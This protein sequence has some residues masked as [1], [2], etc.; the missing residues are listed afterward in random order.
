M[1]QFQ[2]FPKIPRLNREVVVTEK[3][4]GTN[5]AVVI[6]K[7]AAHPSIMGIDYVGQMVSVEGEWYAVAAQSRNRLID[8]AAD[9]Y[10]FAAWVEQRATALVA[11]GEGTH[12]GEWWGHGIQR[13]YGLAKGERYFSLFNSVRYEPLLT[14]DLRM[15]GVET[16]PTLATMDSPNSTLLEMITEGLAAEGSVAAPGF[17]RPEGIVVYH[18]AARQNFKVLLEG[19]D[20]PKGQS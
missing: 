10:G 7:W 9:N 17:M 12:F 15:A 3:L 11:L 19:D 5:A 20:R 8:V 6:E 16:V 4:D 2:P 13:G 14:R 1:I 18:T